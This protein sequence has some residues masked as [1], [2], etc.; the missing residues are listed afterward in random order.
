MGRISVNWG[1]SRGRSS[2]D[3]GWSRGAIRRSRSMVY[4][5]RGAISRSGS[6]SSISVLEGL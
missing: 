3:W 2:I 6:R 5:G 1:W 4:R